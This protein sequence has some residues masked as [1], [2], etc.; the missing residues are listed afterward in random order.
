MQDRQTYQDLTSNNT[1]SNQQIKPRDSQIYQDLNISDCGAT[2][3][4]QQVINLRSDSSDT[5]ITNHQY[6]SIVRDQINLGYADETDSEGS[7]RDRNFGGEKLASSS[8][9]VPSSLESSLESHVYQ[10]IGKDLFQE[11]EAESQTFIAEKI[12]EQIQS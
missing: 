10:T 4:Q 5:T 6:S 9:F 12:S 8:S 7:F 11:I 1:S 2:T 3:T